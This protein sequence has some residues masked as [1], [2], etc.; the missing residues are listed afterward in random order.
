MTETKPNLSE[1]LTSI[2][3]KHIID[4]AI[5]V[6]SEK[7]FHRAKIKDVAKEAGIADGTVYNYFASKKEL[8]LAVLNELN[9][10]EARPA[11]FENLNS[12]DLETLFLKQMQHRFNFMFAKKEVLQAVLP[13]IISDSEIRELYFDAI[14]SPTLKMGEQ[15]F[16]EVL[17]EPSVSSEALTRALAGSLFGLLLLNLLGDDETEKHVA[18]ILGFLAKS[19][20][21]NLERKIA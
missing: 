8:L 19:F 18:E 9:E 20:A 15:A 12:T 7:G 1:Q 13:E 14:I 10:T 21:S 6:F 17:T 4:A 2:K 5:R 16:S 11:Q 3:Q